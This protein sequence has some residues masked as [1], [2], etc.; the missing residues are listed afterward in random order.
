MNDVKEILKQRGTTYGSFEE[1][2]IVAKQLK[3]VL[4]EAVGWEEMEPHKQEALEHIC[5]KISRIVTGN[6]NY[7]DNWADVQGYAALIEQI[8]KDK[9]DTKQHVAKKG[10]TYNPEDEI[11]GYNDIPR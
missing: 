9:Q 10:R 1:N 4:H 2:A 5:T 6:S 8:I 11:I 3:A 7:A